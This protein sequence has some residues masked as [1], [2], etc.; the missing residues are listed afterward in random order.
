MTYPNILRANWVMKQLVNID[1]HQV[2]LS[3][4]YDDQLLRSLASNES[5]LST[6]VFK[7]GFWMFPLS[8][9]NENYIKSLNL[10]EELH[11]I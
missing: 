7:N 1:S 4:S 6:E 9:Q 2:C 3:L 8:R 11:L 5:E 10:G